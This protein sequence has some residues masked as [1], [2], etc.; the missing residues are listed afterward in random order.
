MPRFIRLLLHWLGLADHPEPWGGPAGDCF[1][2]DKEATCAYL[3]K[4]FPPYAVEILS[5]ALGFTMVATLRGRIFMVSQ[6]Y[7]EE[8]TGSQVVRRGKD[9]ITSV[10]HSA[11]WQRKKRT[12]IIRDHSDRGYWIASDDPL[13]G[14]REYFRRITP[15]EFAAMTSHLPRDPDGFPIATP[16]DDDT[17]Q[18][19]RGL[20]RM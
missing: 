12:T 3:Q 7:V 4:R 9:F 5:K 19:A 18:K 6:N 20:P 16:P 17:L 13:R 8:I 1:I 10:F 11:V 2:S 14:Y 15:E